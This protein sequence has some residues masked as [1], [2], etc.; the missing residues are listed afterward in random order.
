MFRLAD[1]N[2][3]PEEVSCLFRELIKQTDPVDIDNDWD[4]MFAGEDES[5]PD[6]T[7]SLADHVTRRT[8]NR[9]VYS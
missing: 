6:E 5:G 8:T 2:A 4:F 7:P 1:S 3:L 9:R